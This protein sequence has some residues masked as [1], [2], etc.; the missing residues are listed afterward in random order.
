MAGVI[1]R[2][3]IYSR[4]SLHGLELALL[5]H[6]NKPGKPPIR[7]RKLII[8]LVMAGIVVGGL[9]ALAQDQVTLKIESA[10]AADDPRFPGYVAA[11]LGVHSTGGNTYEVLTNGDRIFPSML[12]AVNAAQRRR[13]SF[14]TYIYKEGTIGKQFTDAFVA[15]AKRGVQVQLVVDAMGSNKIPKEWQDSLKAAGVKVG[16]FGQTKWYTLEELNYR[17][18]RK[19]L[20]VDGRVA[21]TGGVGLDDQWLGNAQDKEHWRDTM[22]SVRRTGRAAHG[23]SLQRE[24]RRDARAGHARRRSA[25]PDSGRTPRQRDGPP[26]LADRR[27]QRSQAPVP[28]LDCRRASH[29]RHLHAVLRHR[30]IQRLGARRGTPTA[31][32]ACASSSKGI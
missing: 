28:A 25:R 26:Q 16:E 17:T 18:H 2:K 13:I 9:L 4:V 12:A 7:H 3:N 10:H 31:A 21:F 11:L 22:V 32:S 6:V 1:R 5:G 24:L 14:E 23:G 30:R 8:G 19:I 15:A 27:Q 20:V 29:P